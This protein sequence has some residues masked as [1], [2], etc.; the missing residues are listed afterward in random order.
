MLFN[1]IGCPQ[2]G[3]TTTAAMVFSV[4][5][6]FGFLTEFVPEQARQ[7]IAQRRFNMRGTGLTPPDLDD[8]D[9]FNIMFQQLQIDQVMT[10]S[11]G[12]QVT[13]I[14]DSSPLNALLYMTDETRYSSQVKGLIQHH[15][16]MLTHSFYM[17]PVHDP[18]HYADPHRVHSYE[19]SLLIDS[20]IPALL[21]ELAPDLHVTEV[22]GT[23]Q[24][25]LYQVQQEIL[26]IGTR[27]N[28]SDRNRGQGSNS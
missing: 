22:D 20:K 21:K 13:V 10:Y 25:R 14:S 26:A 4:L 23:M 17:K 28:Q 2:S 19:Q 12:D 15:L 3:K 9:Q 6:E 7:Y 5:K 16:R 11:G 1:F 18:N 24:T 27:W 8:N